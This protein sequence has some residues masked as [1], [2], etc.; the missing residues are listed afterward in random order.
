MC[1]I[2]GLDITTEIYS[3]SYKIHCVICTLD[4]WSIMTE[5]QT[6]MV[7]KNNLCGEMF[8]FWKILCIAKFIVA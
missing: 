8:V 4:K 2:F 5:K 7:G 1:Q 3:I 6:E